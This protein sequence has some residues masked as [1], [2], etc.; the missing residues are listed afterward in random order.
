MRPT[1]L[2]VPAMSLSVRERQASD[3]I[4]ARLTSS[5]PKLASLP[6]MFGRLESD[7]KMP[8]REKIS[9]FRRLFP[10]GRHR[11]QRSSRRAEAARRTSSM[12][13]RPS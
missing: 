12:S 6:S 1:E 8:A 10:H 3:S 7:E 2:K 5:D 13:C 9:L 4:E 11:Y